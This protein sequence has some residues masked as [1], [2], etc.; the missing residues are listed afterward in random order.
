M[1]PHS[2]DPSMEKRY[3]SESPRL[4]C[5]IP[6]SAFL[7]HTMFRTTTA[8][9]HTNER[10]R[11]HFDAGVARL[12]GLTSCDQPPGPGLGGGNV[13]PKWRPMT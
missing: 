8:S 2:T 10:R 6:G 13:T 3:A 11:R 9:L 4:V 7:G 5:P 1:K 12:N